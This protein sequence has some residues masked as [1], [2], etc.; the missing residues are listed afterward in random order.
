MFEAIEW[1]LQALASTL[2]GPSWQTVPPYWSIRH[3]LSLLTMFFRFS[4]N[5]T[6]TVPFRRSEILK[7]AWIHNPAYY[8]LLKG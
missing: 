2:A 4:P 3:R 1:K 5:R 8:W 6:V 7:T